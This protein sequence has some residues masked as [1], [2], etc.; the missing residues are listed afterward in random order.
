MSSLNGGNKVNIKEIDK[1]YGI[2]WFELEKF[3]K[4]NYFPY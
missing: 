2:K 3:I 4:K 1:K